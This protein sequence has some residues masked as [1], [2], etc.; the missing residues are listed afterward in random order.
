MT[1]HPKKCKVVTIKRRPSPLTMLPFVAYHYCPSEN[2]LEYVDSERDLGVNIT[3]NCNFNE[4]NV[5]RLT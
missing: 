4:H 2:L 1:F 5:K 3:T